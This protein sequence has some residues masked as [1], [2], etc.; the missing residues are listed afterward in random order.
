M[1]YENILK[2]TLMT[3][4]RENKYCKYLGPLSILLP[5]LFI[6]A[7]MLSG[8]ILKYESA[9]LFCPPY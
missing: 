5:M 3:L 1:I 8:I 2:I 7:S 6:C 9:T 4:K